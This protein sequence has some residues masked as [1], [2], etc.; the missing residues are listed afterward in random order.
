[1]DLVAFD[2]T[3]LFATG[4]EIS[5]HMGLEDNLVMQR[6][7]ERCGVVDKNTRYVITHYSHNNAPLSETLEKARKE[8]GYFPAF[9][10]YETEI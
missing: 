2:C 4:G 9:D 3:F 7:F 1:M 8:Y 5:R 6:E 10:G